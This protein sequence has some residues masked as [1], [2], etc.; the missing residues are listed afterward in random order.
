[1]KELKLFVCQIK[2]VI[3]ANKFDEFM[4]TLSSLAKEFSKE[5]GCYN[6]GL[7]TSID[8]E[9][10][11]MVI[12]EWKTNPAME[13]H[14][15]SKNFTLMIGAIRVLG[16]TFEISISESKHRGDFQL[17]KQKIKLSPEQSVTGT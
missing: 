2:T 7:Y 15:K 14:F 10:T 13:K 12:S 4:E 8:E 1:M 5:K 16:E 3:K 9:N 6:F 11:Y 17:A